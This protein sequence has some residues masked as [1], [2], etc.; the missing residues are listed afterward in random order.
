MGSNSGGGFPR[1]CVCARER[2]AGNRLLDPSASTG[3]LW[4]FRLP[5]FHGGRPG[6]LWI[7][8]L[9]AQTVLGS[10]VERG[11][12]FIAE[13]INSLSV[14]TPL[15]TAGVNWEYVGAHI[16]S[17]VGHSRREIDG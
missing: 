5:G 11:V 4:E 15:P 7:S 16:I 9:F 6:V 13:L 14:S 10:G 2:A 12:G 17:T 3:Y 8:D 1:R